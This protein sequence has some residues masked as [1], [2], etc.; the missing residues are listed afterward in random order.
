MKI[1]L[2]GGGTGGHTFPLI[3]VLREIKKQSLNVINFLYLGPKDAF[4]ESLFLKE[5][6]KISFCSAGKIRRY[7]G[8]STFFENIKDIFFVIP[9]GILQA[10]IKIFFYAPDLIFSKGGYGS[11]PVV[12][13]GTLLRVPIVMHESDTIP[14]QANR[15]IS[16]FAFKIYV[17]F[18]KK[19]VSFFP[20]KKMESVGNPIRETVLNGS[21]GKAKELLKLNFKKPTILVLGGSQGSVRI[22][23]LI[24]QIAP[25]MLKLFEIIHQTGNKDFR[26]VKKYTSALIP[27]ELKSDYHIYPFLNEKELQSAYTASDLIVARAGAGTIFEISANGK[28]SILIPLPESAQNHQ[29]KNAL[30]Y[31]KLTKSAIVIEEKNLTPNFFLGEIKNIFEF[32]NIKEMQKNAKEFGKTNSAEIIAKDIIKFLET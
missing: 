14:G 25:Q 13:A 26:R 11:L 18:D 32:K 28:P 30:T 24:I 17:A 20:L 27:K 15:L 1:I 8:I 21:P 31:A 2:A 3:A 9:L 16:S 10:F 12:I 7:S 19:N 23:E 6:I 4:S 22:N 29:L 5:G